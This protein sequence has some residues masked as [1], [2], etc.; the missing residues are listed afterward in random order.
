MSF[1]SEAK[2]ELCRG[3]LGHLCC[4]RAEAYGVLLYCNVFTAD[5]V[6]VVTEHPAFAA[7]LPRLFAR[8]FGVSF[9]ALPAGGE[10]SKA[11]FRISDEGKLAHIMD[12]LGY[13]RSQSLAAHV[14]LALLEEDCCRAAFLRG[15]FLAGG[16]V[17][18]PEKR[19]HLELAT[20]H[21]R[22]SGEV[23][24]LLR[25][26]GASP[27]SVRRGG[28]YVIYFKQSEHIEDLLTLIGAPV[29]AMEV[30]NTKVE[31]EL[32]NQINR[33]LN[34]DTANLDKTVDAARAQIEGIRKLDKFGVME[35]LPD[36][37]KETAAKR[38]LYPELTL[39][40]LAEEFDPPIT[41]SCLNHR[42]RKIM[43]YTKYLE[44]TQV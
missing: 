16:S 36:K 39:S 7:R 6:R 3:Q 17:I 31:K 37:L 29:A 38:L 43:E 25:E 2:A 32:R 34:C 42:L 41:K 9:D 40:E 21:M 35:Q 28:Y 19:Y 10:K 14:N 15:A 18:D 23:E 33:K 26:M 1:S 12:V 24:A 4:A 11:V 44:G 8:A 30:M 27:K 22:A 5:E 20:T 13:D